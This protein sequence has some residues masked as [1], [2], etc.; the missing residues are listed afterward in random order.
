MTYTAAPITVVVNATPTASFSSSNTSG[1]NY[2]FFN[3]S[4][5]TSP[6]PLTYL[7]SGDNGIVFNSTTAQNPTAVL[8]AGT[9][10]VTLQV[11]GSGCTAT[12]TQNIITAGPSISAPSAIITLPLSAPGSPSNLDTQ[13]VN[14]NLYVFEAVSTGGAIATYQWYIPNANVTGAATATP[15]AVF[16]QPGYYNVTLVVSNASGSYSTQFPVTVGSIPN[17]S[18]TYTNIGNDYTFVNTSSN[19]IGALVTQL[20]KVDG[21]TQLPSDSILNITLPPAI[22]TISLIS[23]SEFSCNS[24]ILDKII[25]VLAPAVAAP[26]A[27]ITFA[28]TNPQCITGNS[29]TLV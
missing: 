15:T 25:T 29:F 10:T 21:I 20:W 26:L 1:N 5:P 12:I 16:T 28:G 19:A 22:Y 13:C 4:Y 23:R 27:T 6:N 8:A 14:S 24:S 11:T 17:A 9:T 2:A 7:W 3:G 18:F